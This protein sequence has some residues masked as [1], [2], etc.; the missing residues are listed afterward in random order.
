MA[1]EI[2]LARGLLSG[3]TWGLIVAVVAMGAVSL[4]VAPVE[5]LETGPD[6][7]PDEDMCRGIGQGWGDGNELWSA[8]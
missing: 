6:S 8:E 5:T 2:G 1:V 7:W 4:L 3:L